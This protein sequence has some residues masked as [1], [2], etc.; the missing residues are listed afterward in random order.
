M[1]SDCPPHQTC[2]GFGFR[3]A[4]V[5]KFLL[6][7]G[8]A[9]YHRVY[10]VRI[11]RVPINPLRNCPKDAMRKTTRE[12]SEEAQQ[13]WR[14]IA[15][16]L[17]QIVCLLD[18]QGRVVRAN[19]TIQRWGW[20]DPAAVRGIDLHEVLHNDCHDPECYLGRFCVWSSTELMAGRHAQC[21]AYDPILN[22]HLAIHAQPTDVASKQWNRY[23]GTSDLLAVV[24][25]DDISAMRVAEERILRHNEAFGDRP[26]VVQPRHREELPEAAK[27]GVEVG[28]AVI[29]MVAK[30]ELTATGRALT[31]TLFGILHEAVNKILDHAKPDSISVSVKR[32]DDL[33]QLCIEEDSKADEVEHQMREHAAN[34]LGLGTMK[35][36]AELSGGVY[37]LKSAVGEGTRISISWPVR[38]ADTA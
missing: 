15:D 2:G 1:A 6:I 31:S 24:T 10:V 30:R 4:S 37:E 9:P 23:Y 12:T 22:R 18:I 27:V 5:Q 26:R 25:I 14:F 17:P 16:S 20:D 34:R 21:N 32:S 8:S 19:H 33:L 7:A 28:Q 29:D 38:L 3:I 13:P 35:Q 11:V 36:R